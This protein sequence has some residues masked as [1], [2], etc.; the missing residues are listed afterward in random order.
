MI[1]IQGNK[2]QE[3][4]HPIQNQQI[5]RQPVYGTQSFFG[6]PAGR[7]VLQ[8][9]QF[10]GN[11]CAQNAMHGQMEDWVIVLHD[12]ENAFR[13]D[14]GCKLLADFSFNALLWSFA[15][16][17]LSARKLPA[18]LVVAVTALCRKDFFLVCFWI[19]AE[20]D[21]SADGYLFHLTFSSTVCNGSRV[22]CTLR[23]RRRKG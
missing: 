18:V 15:G 11:D 8:E 19:C 21:C 2:L 23:I 20:N 17:K 1:F 5:R 10:A 3:F 14:F 12:A 7:F 6:K 9:L 22:F 13:A 4:F 16:L